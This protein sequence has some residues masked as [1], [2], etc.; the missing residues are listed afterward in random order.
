MGVCL[1]LLVPILK[2]L[3]GTSNLFYPSTFSIIS[4]SGGVAV[5][6]GN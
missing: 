1:R 5:G 4:N 2:A 3:E 6:G